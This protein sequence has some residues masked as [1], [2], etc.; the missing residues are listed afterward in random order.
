[1]NS[2]STGVKVWILSLYNPR[3]NLC[4]NSKKKF[5][6]VSEKSVFSVDIG[7]GEM[8]PSRNPELAS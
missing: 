4:K 2:L 6:G 1:M 7:S 8:W 3:L 5:G